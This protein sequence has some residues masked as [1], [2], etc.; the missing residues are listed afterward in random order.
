MT[1]QELERMIRQVTAERD[2]LTG[3]INSLKATR[4]SIIA[5]QKSTAKQPA[6]GIGKSGA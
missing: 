2:Y 4:R 6:A 3:L 5:Q 1:K